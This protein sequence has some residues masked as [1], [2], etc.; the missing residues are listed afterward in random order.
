MTV[1]ATRL[2]SGADT[3]PRMRLSDTLTVAH[4]GPLQGRGGLRYDGG[5][6]VTIV[7]GT[8]RVQVSPFLAWV[9]GST[10]LIQGGYPFVCDRITELTLDDG[11]AAL[12]RV[13]TI[14]AVAWDDVYDSSGRTLAELVAIKGT[15][16]QGVPTLPAACEPLRDV[17]VPAG[18]SAGAGGLLAANAATDRRRYTAALGG[19]I[20][21]TSQAERDGLSFPGVSVYRIDLDRVETYTGG[22]WR[23]QRVMDAGVVTIEPVAG[24]QTTV[25]VTFNETFPSPPAVTVSLNTGYTGGGP[26]PE[27]WAFGETETGCQV[28]LIRDNTTATDVTW[29]AIERTS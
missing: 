16:G 1:Y 27:L 4:N 21:V 8:M 3:A 25:P 10:S 14:A 11:D 17:I 6:E 26:R 19:I 29:H 7:P 5:G 22:V 12:D 15:P 9:D 20:P 28:S 23:H 13:D 24:Q 2:Q 18:V